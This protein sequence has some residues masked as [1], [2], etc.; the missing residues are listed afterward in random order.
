MEDTTPA[1]EKSRRFQRLLELQQKI[2]AE[3]YGELV[4]Q[5]IRVLPESAGKSGEGWLTG[6]SE[7]NIIVEFLAPQKY[8]GQFVSVKVTGSLNWAVLGEIN[9]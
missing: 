6:R 5:S 7:A 2:G 3:K 1:E 8:I 4:G 9:L